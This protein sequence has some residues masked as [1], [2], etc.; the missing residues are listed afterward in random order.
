MINPKLSY[1]DDVSP[2]ELRSYDLARLDAVEALRLNFDVKS[3]Y[4]YGSVKSPGISDLDLI[5]VLDESNQ[6]KTNPVDPSEVLPE[7]VKSI[8]AGGTVMVL[9]SELFATINIWDQLN[10]NLLWGQKLDTAPEQHNAAQLN[11]ARSVDWLP[12]RILRLGQMLQMEQVNTSRA[13]GLV[14]SLCHSIRNAVQ[15]FQPENTKELVEYTDQ[16]DFIRKSWFTTEKDARERALTKSIT[17]GS[18]LSSTIIP[19]LANGLEAQGLLDRGIEGEFHLGQ[20][21]TLAFS[22]DKPKP[23]PSQS[24]DQSIVL[25]T[26]FYEHFKNYAAPTGMIG[27]KIQS[28]LSPLSRHHDS[29][30]EISYVKLLQK[31]LDWVERQATFISNMGIVTGLYKFGWFFSPTVRGVN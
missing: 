10:T 15:Q 1:I 21:G 17:E 7:H 2:R 25:P 20:T 5:I 30:G 23:S 22:N 12:E 3:I 8:A 14:Y 11:L 19:L 24:S 18:A 13:I 28:K 27:S 6:S 4:E 16:I 29:E 26:I 31:R 9:N